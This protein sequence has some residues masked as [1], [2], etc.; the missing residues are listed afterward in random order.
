MRSSRPAA[1]AGGG[2]DDNRPGEMALSLLTG[3]QTATGTVTPGPKSSE[4]ARYATSDISPEDDVAM[5]IDGTGATFDDGC[6]D[7][8][9]NAGPVLPTKAKGKNAEDARNCLRGI[10][11]RVLLPLLSDKF[12]DVRV[13]RPG[14]ESNR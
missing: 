7:E 11:A 3:C 5:G 12:N 10:L 4:R 6:E 13:L 14:A 8:N 2:S 1:F 9:A